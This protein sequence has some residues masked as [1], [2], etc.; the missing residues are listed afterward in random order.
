MRSAIV[1]TDGIRYGGISRSSI[2]VSP[3]SSV[4]LKSHA[5]ANAATIPSRYMLNMMPAFCSAEATG[6]S[7]AI[8]SA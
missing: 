1:R 4:F 6:M 3:R 2:G 8:I 5:I 7:T